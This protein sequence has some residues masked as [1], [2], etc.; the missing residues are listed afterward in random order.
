MKAAGCNDERQN[1]VVP[2]NLSLLRERGIEISFLNHGARVERPK[3]SRSRGVCPAN[4]DSGTY[5]G[6]TAEER[7]FSLCR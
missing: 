6:R 3:R 2:R 5:I 4:F 7:P 1:I